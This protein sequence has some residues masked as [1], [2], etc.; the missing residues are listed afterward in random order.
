MKKFIYSTV[1]VMLIAAMAGCS[2][3]L[4]NNEQQALKSDA[5]VV[6]ENILTRKSVR[7][8]INDPIPDDVM[9]DLLRAAMAA[10]TGMNVQPWH[11]IVLKDTSRYDEIFGDNF[12]MRMYKE[13]SAVIIFC[14]D[15]TVTRPPR[16]N[17]DAP[18][19]TSPNSIWRDDMGAC[20]ENFL[21]AVE[22]YG[23]GAC[24]TA[25][26]PYAERMDPIR[27]A[28][29]IPDNFVPYSVVPVGT[30]AGDEMPKD[31]WKP[32][33]VHYDTW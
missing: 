18:A 19:V 13:S 9:E 33:K 2:D 11:I 10:P 30:P 5:D 28:L 16:D 8:F 25:C 29:N 26:Y 14:A 23:L 12:N 21:L 6:M 32:E 22:A 1:I 27:K 31:K 17:P 15:T 7:H 24:W 3:F 4:D 20:T